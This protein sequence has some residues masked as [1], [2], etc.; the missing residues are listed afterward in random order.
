MFDAG[1][2]FVTTLT[3]LWFVLSIMLRSRRLVNLKLPS[4]K[5]FDTLHLEHLDVRSKSRPLTSHWSTWG[6]N[7]YTHDTISN[8]QTI[9]MLSRLFLRF[10]RCKVRLY[11]DVS[12]DP[13]MTDWN[14]SILSSLRIKKKKKKC[15]PLIKTNCVR[16]SK[17]QFLPQKTKLV[18]ISGSPYRLELF[19]CLKCVLSVVW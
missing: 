7:L 17:N 6:E 16:C 8:R 15:F 3:V 14:D 11:K 13:N 10:F 9:P 18:M 2:V 4:R 5:H 12:R 19:W 1:D